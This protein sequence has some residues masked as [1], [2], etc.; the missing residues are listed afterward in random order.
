VSQLSIPL[1]QIVNDTTFEQYTGSKRPDLLISEVEFEGDNEYQF[2]ANLVAYAEVKDNCSV[3]DR[4]WINAMDQ[5]KIKSKKLNLP[6]FIVTNCK[7]SVF[8][9]R[10]TGGELLVNKNPIREFQ[11][12]DIL[13]LIKSRLKKNPELQNIQTNVDSI[14]TIS[15]ALFNKKLWELANI[16][17]IISFK[18][19]TQLIDF[20]IGFIA[21]KYFE[22]KTRIE[23][24]LDKTKI[25]WTDC[26]NE[27]AE[28]VVANLARYTQRLESE[29]DFN[30]FKSL[31]EIV[32]TLITG[33]SGKT[34]L[35]DEKDVK[36]IYD[37]I[38]SMG[39]LHGC[40]FDLFGAVYEMFA[41]SKEKKD[42][43]EYFTRRHY[44][45]VFAKLLLK[46]E[47]YF[48]PNKKFKILNP[49]CGTG[50]FLTESFK[51][52]INKVIG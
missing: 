36:F 49:A 17:R 23:G 39:R 30:E 31:M 52:L 4:D 47:G 38:Q 15:E 18:D 34:P 7:T 20:T 40:G 16:Y 22:E 9:N 8:Y 35:I 50:G 37:A 3:D 29:T 6:Y 14:S 26:D 27:F 41:S 33:E 45:H 2:V 24:I 51:V 43:G 12:I 44:A 48:N 13:R 19:K 46:N 1:R 10:D 28:R 11:T 25:Y 32:R 42:F 21:L 5:G